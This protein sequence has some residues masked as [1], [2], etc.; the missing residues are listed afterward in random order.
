MPSSLS[1]RVLWQ[2]WCW[3]AF[4]AA[5]A[6]RGAAF[7]PRA[8]SVEATAV[9]GIADRKWLF[10]SAGTGRLRWLAGRVVG[11]D[12]DRAAV[13]VEEHPAHRAFAQR[14]LAGA[15]WEETNYWQQ[16]VRD[17]ERSVQRI[18]CRSRHD[19]DRK[20]RGFD[21]LW[22]VLGTPA[23]RPRGGPASY[24]PWEEVLL[25]VGRGGGLLLVDGRHRLILAHLKRCRLPVFV[26]LRHPEAPARPRSEVAVGGEAVA[27]EG[28]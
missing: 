9:G 12:W 18:G 15:P 14:F 22:Q 17:V 11:G 16:V 2:A 26:I 8:A 19:V 13:P 24:R 20:F 3:S 1:A 25:G 10:R 7:L 21:D 27:E 6:R 5:L 23:Y 4:A 28:R